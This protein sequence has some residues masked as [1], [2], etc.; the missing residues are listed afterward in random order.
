MMIRYYADEAEPQLHDIVSD[1]YGCLSLVTC[2]RTARKPGYVRILR[3][4]ARDSMFYET[5]KLKLVRRD[6]VRWSE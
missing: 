4:H 2:P 5:A 3:Q 6:G 1:E